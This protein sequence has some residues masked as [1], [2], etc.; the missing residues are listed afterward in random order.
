MFEKDPISLI[1][2]N[3]FAGRANRF[4]SRFIILLW[5]IQLF[6]P[7]GIDAK[8]QQENIDG[9]IVSLTPFSPLH[10]QP[11]VASQ[12][13]AT[14]QEAAHGEGAMMLP[15]KQDVPEL[16]F[17]SLLEKG[18]GDEG[19][20]VGCGIGL[21]TL[22]A[23][24]SLAYLFLPNAA[25]PN[26]Y[27]V[28]KTWVGGT[29][30]RWSNTN[31]WNPTGLPGTTD[32]VLFTTNVVKC[33]LNTTSPDIYKLRID[34]NYTGTNAVIFQNS[35][36]TITVGA[37]G[38]SQAGG[39]FTGSSG[40]DAITV[41]GDFTLSGGSFTSTSGTLSVLG[42][43]GVNNTGN[44]TVSGSSS[45]AH[46]N[47]QVKFEHTPTY[48]GTNS[49]TIAV[50][51]TA[52]NQL[53]LYSLWINMASDGP[54]SSMIYSLSSDTLIVTKTYTHGSTGNYGQLNS[55]VII[56]QDSI[57]V[58][59]NIEYGD[60]YTIGVGNAFL[61]AAGSA[62]QYYSSTGG[63]LPKLIIDKSNS[64]LPASGTKTLHV[65]DFILK[66]GTFSASDTL[67]INGK[68]GYNNT[69]NFTVTGG[70]FTHNNGIV[71]F[72]HTPGY[73]QAHTATIAINL[74]SSNQLTFGSLWFIPH[75]NG[76][77]G[78]Q[79][80]TLSSDT[81][82]VTGSYKQ[83]T[84]EEVYINSG[85]ILAQGNVSF[86]N[87]GS[88]GG[89]ASMVFTGGAASQT[90]TYAGSAMLSGA[91]KVDKTSGSVVLGSNI[92]FPGALQITS[93]GLCNGASYNLTVTGNMTIE[94]SGTYTDTGTG[95][96]TLGG[97]L[98]NSGTVTINGNGTACGGADDIAIASTSGGTS[99]N[100][101]GS[102]NFNIVDV[103][104]SDQT[105]TDT[106]TAYSST[107]TAGS[108]WRVST[109]CLPSIQQPQT[110]YCE[111][112]TTPVSNVTDLTPEFSAIFDDNNTSD[113]AV[114]YEVKVYTSTGSSLWSSG[115]IAISP[116]VHENNRCADISYNGGLLQQNG[117]TYYWGIRFWNGVGDVS[118]WSTIQQ[119]TMFNNS[120]PSAPQTP[121]CE[122]QSTPVTGVTDF[123]PEFS[124]VYDDANTSDQA[125]Y[126]QVQVYSA[127]APSGWWNSSWKYRRALVFNNG[128]SAENLANFP[129]LVVLNSSRVDYANT[130]NSGQDI[131]F[132]DANGS[133]LLSHEIETWNESGNSLVWVKVPQIDASS[134]TD[135]I[136]M[137]YGNSGASDGQDKTNV[138]D[139]NYKVTLHMNETSGS[140]V[141]DSKNVN[142]G[143]VSGGISTTTGKVSS[144][145]SFN[146]SSQYIDWGSLTGI[147]T[148]NQV[149]TVEAWI[150]P[151]SAS[152]STRQ[153]LM[154]LGQEGSGA[155]S[156][157]LSNNQY[158]SQFGV[159][160]VETGQ[161]NPVFSASTWTHI[162]VTNDGTN[163]KLYCNGDSIISKSTT[164]NLTSTTLNLAERPGAVPSEAY[165]N[166]YL[167]EYRLSA[168]ARSKAWI[169]A[170]YKSMTDAYITF[171]SDEYGG[172]TVWNSGKTAQTALNENSRCADIS[173]AGSALSASTSYYWRIRFWDNY[174]ADG[175]WSDL[176]TFTTAAPARCTWI[177]SANGNWATGAN[178]QTAIP[179]AGDTA[180]FDNN[181]AFICTLTAD[182]GVKGIDIK[183]TF[184]GSVYQK[185][186]VT[187]TIGTGGYSQAGGTF[188][189]N[190]ARIT[191]TASF[192]VSGGTF[193]STSDTLEVQGA[194]FNVS[195]GSFTHSSGKVL[196]RGATGVTLTL[197]TNGLNIVRVNKTYGTV[198]MLGSDLKLAGELKLSSGILNQG[199]SHGLKTGGQ[200]T[201]DYGSAL[202]DT[203]SGYDSLGGDVSN[204]GTILI[205]GGGGMCGVG[206]H[207]N[208]RSTDATKRTWSGAGLNSIS[209]VNCYGMKSTPAI[210]AWHSTDEGNNDANWVVKTVCYDGPA[211][212]F[213]LANETADNAQF[214][215]SVASAGD[216][217]GDGYAD[218][219]AG[220]SNKGNGVAYV[221]YGS[222]SGLHTTPDVT[223][224]NETGSMVYFGY[225]V[226][227]AGDVNG[228]GYADVIVGAYGNDNHGMAYIFYGSASGLH[229]TPDVTITET[230]SNAMLGLSVSS[231]GDVNGDGYADV[232]VGAPY[233]N[234]GGSH[235]G[236]A[237]IFYGGSSMDATPD[238]TL[239][240]ETESSAWFG[241]S[242]SSAGDVNGDGYADVIVGASSE[243]NGGLN[244]GRAYIYY[245][246]S[247]MDAAPDVTLNNE[248]TYFGEFGSSVSS[249]G[250]VNNDGYSDV[251][252]AAPDCLSLVYFLW[253]RFDECH[254]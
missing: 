4:I 138:W 5:L 44:F 153:W 130:Q 176:Q 185:S 134:N 170:Q 73:D 52:S 11:L 151:V 243:D 95:N 192:T 245:G 62:N 238:V 106:M 169:S 55:G 198:V 215:T 189:G 88:Y 145:L 60:G 247:S 114:F 41:N 205:D 45:F 12:H 35:G 46:N 75:G 210:N 228:D 66:S 94:A 119:F 123:T 47:G 57:K 65:N 99:R 31:N 250:D 71:R 115:K 91:W 92:T 78:S 211:P 190:N 199:A 13:A 8:A 196:F 236:L 43:S 224:N 227:S 223:L 191:D 102:G 120:A 249:A 117:T 81:L 126:Y 160:E 85:V 166:G 113:S 40:G 19:G 108:H 195:A 161:T 240:N 69:G 183:S 27:A 59:G 220:A 58:S 76:P 177:A 3:A 206:S 33:S 214:G 80:Y 140:T 242:V 213:T 172:T 202:I 56:V 28:L 201:V 251:I 90:L 34:A 29:D 167:D 221:F 82:I 229:T 137:Y 248:T 93:G 42:I 225:S 171:R 30:K 180:I 26:A 181:S 218:V 197:G 125:G 207:I 74:P 173:Y 156:W 159:W 103:T 193:T 61:V 147:S 150:N 68:G 20:F 135:S 36:M 104:I 87:S 49:A 105:S 239:N 178:W 133:T 63:V 129:V 83:G 179:G 163:I 194:A 212:S 16:P 10:E 97:L 51:L 86:L 22:F 25:K 109:G 132:V 124:A 165:Y 188:T 237:Y 241:G 232:I 48:D 154:L 24:L 67:T 77:G 112:Q 107:G 53:T 168:S 234:N 146:G 21:P 246:G 118:A 158:G 54:A 219:I 100:W 1:S 204:A 2:I 96:L 208:L 9:S 139:A 203:G 23:T 141:Y 235:C 162:V 174:D 7:F 253:R 186:G 187:L 37:G 217:N 233:H 70:S 231:A 110:P 136:W 216:V 149:H 157:S 64:L 116:A 89:S 98:S 148:G 252:V 184:A 50:N 142:N 111:G 32:T 164:F 155:H 144:A 175:A 15:L 14:L 209:D 6:L 39:T 121:Y 131:R 84:S 226:A 79:T 18:P 143:T 101:S 200:L 182:P 244:C 222:A 254:A 72:A 122:G 38:F 127:A 152:P 17:V 128:A 230:E